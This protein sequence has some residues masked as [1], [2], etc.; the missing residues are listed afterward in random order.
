MLP[1]RFCLVAALSICG[2]QADALLYS[3]GAD[4]SGIPR[5]F[6]AI[7][8][9]GTA[10]PV[11][12][13]GDGSVAFL[14]GI[15]FHA[16]SNLFYA[17]ANDSSGNSNLVS[18]SISGGGTFTSIASLGQGFLSGLTFGGA[19]DQLFAISTDSFG[20]SILNTIT[21]TGVVTPIG[22]L[23]VGFYGGLSYRS[24]DGLLYA[25]SGDSFGVQRQFHSIDS[26]T[27]GATFLFSLGDGSSAFSGGVAWDASSG[28]FYVIANDSFGTSTLQS[29]TLSG[30]S[31]RTV[32]SPIGVGF[33][34]AALTLAPVAIPE[35]ATWMLCALFAA[36][37]GLRIRAR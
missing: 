29:F 4:S 5:S 27:A 18:F 10:Q 3:I 26:A 13:L 7:T 9:A 6:T 35:P 21:V 20:Q 17:I 22:I 31:S 25:I 15:A 37:F 33:G 19:A 2:L 36:V 30:D 16:P 24:D 11:F 34:N 32:I 23:G 28:L 12:D 8:P 1:L 14:G